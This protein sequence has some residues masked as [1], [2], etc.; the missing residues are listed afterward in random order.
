MSSAES[1]VTWLYLVRHGATAAN[2]RVPYTLQGNAVDLPL[3]PAGEIQAR[4]VA[5]FLAQFPISRVYGSHL[6]RSR[7]T[8]EA[9]ALLQNASP[10]LVEDLH[11]CDVGLWEG[12][13]WQTIRER[14]P[15]EHRRFVE[16]T[17]ETPYL[18]GESYGGVLRR[19]MPVIERLCDSHTGESIAIVAHNVVNRA[20]LAHLLG[21][22]LQRAPKIA[23]ANGCVNLIR[24][25]EGQSELVTL[26]SVFHL[27]PFRGL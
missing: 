3:S 8:A 7:Q 24:R 19:T 9:I 25:H 15:Q 6:L 16:D 1:D 2:E 21:L 11:E 4:E 23:Q 20:L 10:H 13:D 5:A 22:G 27:S 14:Y 18:G 17:A 26:N 12:L